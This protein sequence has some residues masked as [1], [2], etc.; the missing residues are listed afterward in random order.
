MRTLNNSNLA[1]FL[2]IRKCVINLNK[3]IQFSNNYFCS[4]QYLVEAGIVKHQL[5]DG[6]PNAEI[7]PLNLKS[8]ERQLRNSDL[9]TTYVVILMGFGVS[10]TVFLGEICYRYRNKFCCT[11]KLNTPDGK[12]KH[13]FVADKLEQHYKHL[14]PPP[15]HSLFGQPK[16]NAQKKIVNGRDYWVI[17]SFEGD[18]RLIPV[19]QP[20]ALLFQYTQ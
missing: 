14:P 17:K 16:E 12:E 2:I 7:C 9:F 8:K 13:N 18:T 19:R 10:G 5:G 1:M 15:Y 20:S 3:S 6:L 11:A 4:L